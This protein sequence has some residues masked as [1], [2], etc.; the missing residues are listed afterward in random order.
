MKHTPESI[1][2]SVFGYQGFKLFQREVIGDVLAGRHAGGAG[3]V[4]GG[5]PGD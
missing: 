4:P 1:L 2:R 5:L 3:A